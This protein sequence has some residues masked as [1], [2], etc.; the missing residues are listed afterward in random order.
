[1][2]VTT[3]TMSAPGRTFY[4]SFELMIG[5]GALAAA[6][7]AWFF[8]IRPV[9]IEPGN[10]LRYG[11]LALLLQ[12]LVRDVV[13]LVFYR[14]TL[15]ATDDAPRS[16]AWICLES[17]LGLGLIALSALFAL[18]EVHGVM[19]LSTRSLALLGAL[20]WLF[21]YAT[22]DYILELRKETN[23]LN[24]LVSL[25]PPAKP[26]AGPPG[27]RPAHGDLSRPT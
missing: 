11:G 6:G 7:L 12:G 17:T 24:L 26:E 20:W 14:E 2:G 16:G 4:Q 1:M 3:S 19:M 8:P 27:P 18:F 21:G 22:R 25:R 23:H 10:F 5:L 15:R 9:G 13:L